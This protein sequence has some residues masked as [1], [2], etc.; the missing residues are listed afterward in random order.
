MATRT[1]PPQRDRRA[2]KPTHG[3]VYTLTDPRDDVVRY[4]GQT[5]KALHERLAG[6]LQNSTNDAMWVWLQILKMNG[7]APIATMIRRVP[8]ED[9][10]AAE[11]EEIAY[12]APEGNLLNHPYGRSHVV[13]LGAELHNLLTRSD[14]DGEA[15]PGTGPAPVVITIP[16]PAPSGDRDD[17]DE[18]RERQPQQHEH[19]HRYYFSFPGRSHRH[20]PLRILRTGLSYRWGWA[21][22]VRLRTRRAWRNAKRNPLAA[23]AVAAVVLGVLVKVALTGL[24]EKFARA[25]WSPLARHLLP[26][27]DT[28]DAPVRSYLSEHAAGLPVGVGVLRVVWWS[29]GAVILFTNLLRGVWMRRLAWAAYG[30]ATTAMV[31]AGSISTTQPV[32]AGLAGLLW[33]LGLAFV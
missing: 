14:P 32:A 12:H 26:V 31:W 27:L 15:G 11:G 9:L 17:E 25:C 6:H 13:A 29:A 16:A 30:C 2:S 24:P 10:L 28:V 7:Q 19:E 3:I 22:S 8:R 20:R 1:P 4:V 18:D 21:R 33:L 5:E 23:A